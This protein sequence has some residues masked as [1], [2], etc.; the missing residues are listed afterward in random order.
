MEPAAY[1]AIVFDK[2][3]YYEKIDGKWLSD[4]EPYVVVHLS[5]LPTN[6]LVSTSPSTFSDSR[7]GKP[8]P[9]A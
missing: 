5:P 2:D 4:G 1:A 3:P 9:R 6:S 7:N 8:V